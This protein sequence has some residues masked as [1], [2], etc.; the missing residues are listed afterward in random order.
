MP[1]EVDEVPLEPRNDFPGH[2]ELPKREWH[3]ES[4]RPTYIKDTTRRNTTPSAV[5]AAAATAARERLFLSVRTSLA[6]TTTTTATKMSLCHRKTKC[7]GIK[8]RYVKSVVAG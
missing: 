6:T 4:A 3:L 2:D 1:A 5:A 8:V 7:S